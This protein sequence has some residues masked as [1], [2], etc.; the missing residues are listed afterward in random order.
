MHLVGDI[1]GDSV[2]VSDG[3]VVG[4]SVGVSDGFRVGDV[5]GTVVLGD[6]DGDVLGEEVGE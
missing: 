3:L 2:G 6:A 1:V 4:D 5:V